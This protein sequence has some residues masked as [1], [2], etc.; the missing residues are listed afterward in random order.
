MT[1]LEKTSVNVLSG[2][3]EGRPRVSLGSWAFAFGP[4]EKDPWSFDRVCDFAAAAGYDGVEINGFRPHPHFDDF[5]GGK[6]SSELKAQISGS[7]SWDLGLRSELPSRASTASGDRDIPCR[8]RQG[9][10]ILRT[11]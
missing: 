1:S 2:W 4:Y 3:Q 7:W 10:S 5:I 6:R 11:A 9:S 8:N